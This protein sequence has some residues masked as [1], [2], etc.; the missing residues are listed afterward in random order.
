MDVLGSKNR[1][2]IKG[3][4]LNTYHYFKDKKIFT[5]KKNSEKFILNGKE[6]AIGT[7]HI[8]ILNEFITKKKSSKNLEIQKYLSFKIDPFNFIIILI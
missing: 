7:G 1:I 2:I 8:K 6:N 5:D 4:S 3:I